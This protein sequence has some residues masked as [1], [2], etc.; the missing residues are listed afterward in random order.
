MSPVLFER[1]VIVGPG[2]IG[3]SLGQA[4]RAEGLARRVVGVGHRQVSMA[5]ALEV[6][7]VDEATLDLIAAVQE[8]DLVVLATSVGKISE[9]AAMIAPKMRDGAILT[10]VG[11]VKGPLCRQMDGLLADSSQ[12][13]VRFVGGHPLAGS[14]QRGVDAARKDLFRNARCILT[15]TPRTNP[16]AL[17]KVRAL[18][19][20]VGCRVLALSPERHDQ[21]LAEMSHLP[22]AVAAGLVNIVS[23]AAFDLAA[24]GFMDTTRVASGDPGLWLDICLANREPLAAALRALIPELEQFADR[25]EAADRDQIL[26]LLTR[27]K[28]RRDGQR[29]KDASADVP[30]PR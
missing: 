29:G 10:D 26:A 9:Q 27:A 11:S 5:R 14:E 22:H 8:A 1:V 6:G 2:L 12:P 13:G 4:L 21:L 23:D 20:A 30:Q 28:A 19:E 15:P 17:A 7:A 24:A 3:G 25:L 18:W 16:D